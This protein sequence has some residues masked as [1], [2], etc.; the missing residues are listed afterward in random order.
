MSM[1]LRDVIQRIALFPDFSEPK[2]Y[3][4]VSLER[5]ERLWPVLSLRTS[6]AA[7]AIAAPLASFTNPVRL[8]F[9]P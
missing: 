5:V 8:A 3:S 1:D 9:W 4:P 7:L 2:K 6:T